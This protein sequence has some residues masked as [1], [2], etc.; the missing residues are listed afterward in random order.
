M[1]CLRIGCVGVYVGRNMDIKG[2]CDTRYFVR[3]MDKTRLFFFSL[4]RNTFFK[5]SRMNI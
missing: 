3:E 4:P 5:P 1:Y 2:Y